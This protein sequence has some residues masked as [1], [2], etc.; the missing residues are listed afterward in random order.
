[1]REDKESVDKG[2]TG[3]ESATIVF[4][5]LPTTAAKQSK[6]KQGRTFCLSNNSKT[7]FGAKTGFPIY[8]LLTN[9]KTFFSP[10][11]LQNFP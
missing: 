2:F 6:A 5:L 9:G 1:M 8:F 7:F 11:T 10:I 4:C 3:C